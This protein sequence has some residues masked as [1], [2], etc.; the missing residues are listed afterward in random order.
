MTE[1]PNQSPIE[2]LLAIMARLR[3]PERGCEWD[4]AQDFASIAPY[5]IEEAYE[6]ADAIARGDMADLRDELGDLLLQVVFHARM[7]EEAGLFAF[8]DVAN[9]I[10]TKMEARHPHIF[11]STGGTMD[12]AR[13]EDLKAKEREAKG[14]VSALDGVALALPALMRAE[15]LQKRAAR[16]GFDWPD[17]SGSEAK[18]AE[19]IEEL[20]TASS[21]E[22]KVEEAGDLLFAAVN[23]VRAHGISAEDALR[24]ANAKFERRF[25]GMEALAGSD[26]PSLSLEAQEDLWQRV[27]QGE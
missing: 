23:F 26:F 5:T 11:A 25:R 4:L 20:K 19:E 21:D 12:E 22:Q 18:I 27:K 2:R 14:V 7:A 1:T 8:T 3:D 16:T 13:W 6:V 9:A 17:P 10:N 24:S 15:K